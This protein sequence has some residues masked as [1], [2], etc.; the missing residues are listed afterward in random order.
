MHI[1]KRLV[2]SEALRNKIDSRNW[3]TGEAGQN[4]GRGGTLKVLDAYM[5][6]KLFLKRLEIKLTP[7]IGGQGM[8]ARVWGV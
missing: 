4:W 2:I 6:L 5:H 3:G 1:G 7:E 8:Q